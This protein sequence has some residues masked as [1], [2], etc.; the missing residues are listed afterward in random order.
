MAKA[1]PPSPRQPR[2]RSK[3]EVQSVRA[4]VVLCVAVI[5]LILVV[6]SLRRAPFAQGVAGLV[7]ALLVAVII[8][9][10]FPAPTSVKLPVSLVTASGFYL[11]LLPR[12]KPFIFPVGTLSGEVR[13]EGTSEVVEGAQIR[14]PGSR[15]AVTDA[16]GAFALTDVRSDVTEFAIRFR[17]FDTTVTVN[18]RGIYAVVPKYRAI[19]SATRSVGADRWIER[20]TNRC[21]AAA[22]GHGRMR[23]F[24][25]TDT[26]VAAADDW[27]GRRVSDSTFH[28][29]VRP[30]DLAAIAIAVLSAPERATRLDVEAERPALHWFLTAPP[31]RVPVRLEVCVEKAP[32]TGSAPLQLT[33][34]LEGTER[35]KGGSSQ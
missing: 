11:A 28:L 18:D 14:L 13:Y 29:R 9:A 35:L 19:T 22:P 5:V 30:T 21:A 33:Y 25:V 34:W 26:L 2:Q 24:A 16:N 12:I 31:P 15:T 7:I 27:S 10:L 6:P 17:Q 4:L 8:F 3:L 23:M 20:T 1:P 32:S